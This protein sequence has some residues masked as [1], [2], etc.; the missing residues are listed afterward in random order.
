M[1]QQVIMNRKRVSTRP[2][3]QH[4]PI[5]TSMLY[6]KISQWLMLSIRPGVGKQ[7]A[8]GFAEQHHAEDL[9]TMCY[10][11]LLSFKLRDGGQVI[12]WLTDMCWVYFSFIFV[13]AG[14]FI[15]VVFWC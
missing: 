5:N 3:L 6:S 13:H 9:E 10:I 1:N 4:L 2:I 14:Y 11:I 15:G 7:R 8:G 12:V